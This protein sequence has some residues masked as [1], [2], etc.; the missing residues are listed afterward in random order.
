M[1]HIL[2]ASWTSNVFLINFPVFFHQVRLQTM[3]KP[4]AGQP[5]MYRGTFD[6]AKQILLKEVNK[7]VTCSLF[8]DAVAKFG[9]ITVWLA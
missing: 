6:C 1:L 9:V 5:P 4:M 3:T 2:E 7:G 8:L